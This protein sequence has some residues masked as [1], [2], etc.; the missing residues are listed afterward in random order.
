MRPYRATT[1][2][3]LLTLALAATAAAQPPPREPRERPPKLPIEYERN[4]ETVKQNNEAPSQQKLPPFATKSLKDALEAWRAAGATTTPGL[5]L[6]WGEFLA[7]KEVYFVAV[8]IMAAPEIGLTAGQ[9]A[10]LFGEVNGPRGAWVLSFEVER[11]VETSRDR[12]YLDIPLTLAPGEYLAQLGIAQG[13]AVKGFVGSYLA[14]REIEKRTFGISRLI[15]S[16]N[17]FP[18]PSKQEPDQPFAFGGIKVVPRSDGTFRPDSEPWLFL[19]VRWPDTAASAAPRLRAGVKLTGPAGP[20]STVRELKV[21]DPAP[22][23]LQG[24]DHQ[25]GLG[26]PLSLAALAAGEYKVEVEVNDLGTGNVLASGAAFTL[27]RP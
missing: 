24:F 13:G 26:L 21:Q 2:T 4:A 10:T 8:Q 16:D 15:L 7:P 17:V 23:P 27:V 5:S 1:G 6:S 20:A 25:F 9:K 19:V 12:T 14:P 3:L 11:P 22:I 18:L